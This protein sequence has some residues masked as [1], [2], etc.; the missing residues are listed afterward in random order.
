MNRIRVDRF[1]ERRANRARCRL[2]RIGRAHQL[3]IA[4]NGVFAFEHLH[5]DRSRRHEAH[6]ILEKG[7]IAMHGIETFRF[8]TGQSHHPRCNDLEPGLFES[9][10]DLPDDILGHRIGFDNR[11]RTF[12]SHSF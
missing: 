3:A 6:E 4:G 2:F 11:Q 12:D 10:I 1:G 7:A 9:G 8:G 5:H